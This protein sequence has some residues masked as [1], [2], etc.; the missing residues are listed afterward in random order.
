MHRRH[1]SKIVYRNDK[2]TLEAR[3]KRKGRVSKIRLLNP[4]NLRRAVLNDPIMVRQV[5]AKVHKRERNKSQEGFM[6]IYNNAKNL[7]KISDSSVIT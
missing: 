7:S 3:H 1:T 2:D 6:S 5:K 4:S